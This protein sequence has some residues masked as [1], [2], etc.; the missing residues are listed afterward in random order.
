MKLS[1]FKTYLFGLLAL[2]LALPAMGANYTEASKIVTAEADEKPISGKIV[3]EEGNPLIGASIVVKGTG[4]GT[5]TDFEGN[6]S[7]NVSEEASTLIITYVGFNEREIEINN[8]SVF[9][10]T[11]SENTSVL[12]EVVVIGYGTDTKEKFN[13]AVS[14]IETERLNNFATANFEQAIAG[15]IAGVQISSNGKN[16]GD[17]GVIQIRGLSTLNAGSD[18]L[19]VVDGNPLTEGSALSS[20]S[21]QDIESINVLKDAASAAIYGSR[22]SNGVILIT[23]KKGREGRL[24]VTYDGYV[25]FQERIDNFELADA[26]ET[27]KF[28]F[29]ARNFGYISGGPGRSITDDNATRDANGGGKRSRIQPFLQGYL[30]GTPGLTN[31]DWTDAIFR[32]AL[33]TNHYINVAG[34]TSKSDFAI[35]LNYFDQENI[36][37][38]SDYRRYT[39][40]LKINT[41]INDKIRVGVSA[42][43]AFA[44]ATPTGRRGWSDYTVSS[45]NTPD[46]AF[47]I[48]LMHP[49]YPIYNADGTLAVD[50]QLQDNNDNWDG[51]ISG[52]IVALAEETDYT[53]ETFRVFG[54]TF[55]EI[56][57][58]EIGRAHV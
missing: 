17:N 51:P 11:L 9:N 31:T 41:A 1:L 39:T 55:L 42:N 48:I 53:Q 24:Q 35:S 10:I 58:V 45:G 38:D 3:D 52:N 50:A 43:A 18:P 23:T 28:D 4:E 36:I 47:T 25:G 19:I 44:D 15:N 34:G 27:A 7:F 54:N 12:D 56:E 2:A 13:G 37:I 33:Q 30:D 16:P 5:V 29:D 22:A 6:F 40:N 20:I 21:T 8:Q 32:N 49:Y 57:P 46:P 26:Y 14:K